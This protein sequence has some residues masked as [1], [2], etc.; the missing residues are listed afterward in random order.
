MRRNLP[1]EEVDRPAWDGIWLKDRAWD[2]DILKN[3]P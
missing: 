3:R 1:R 2:K